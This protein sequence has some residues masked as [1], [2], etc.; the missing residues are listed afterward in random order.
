MWNIQE[1]ELM[2]SQPLVIIAAET[3]AVQAQLGDLLAAEVCVAGAINRA[4]LYD[5]L[6]EPSQVPDLLILEQGLLEENL[7]TFCKRWY[8]HPK[9]RGCDIL[10]LGAADDAQETAALVAGVAD[11]LRKPLSPLLALTRI[12]KQLAQRAQRRHLEALSVT[13]GLTHIANRRYLDEFLCAEWRRAQR[14]GGNIGLMMVDID[15]FKLFNDHYGHPE[16][17]RCLAQVA[18]CLKNAV[19]R[20]RDLV[21]RYG[22]EEFAL[23]LPSIQFDGMAVVA[24]RLQD[25]VDQ[26][27]IPHVASPVSAYITVSIGLAW[28]EPQADERWE[29]LL[30]ASDE[31]LYAAKAAGRHQFSETVNL[32]SVRQLLT[33]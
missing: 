21:A 32:A 22:G 30:A 6:V 3:L 23:V 19:Q 24:Q 16:G 11:Y 31:A 15:H 18:Q 33:H 20:P 4:Q 1:A 12:K 27:A 10:L 7:A 25:A 13:D 9:T 28:C 14:E 2:S 17:D 29:L 8:D 5:W 26:L